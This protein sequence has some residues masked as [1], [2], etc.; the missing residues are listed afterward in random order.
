VIF[1]SEAKKKNSKNEVKQV[2]FVFKNNLNDKLRFNIVKT[3]TTENR[4]RIYQVIKLKK[5]AKE[6]DTYSF[7]KSIDTFP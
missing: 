1:Y 7:K 2:I 3:P 6:L 5:I 4:T